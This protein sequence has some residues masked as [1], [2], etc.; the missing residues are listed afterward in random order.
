M[1]SAN[2]LPEGA[3]LS[4]KR[5]HTERWRELVWAAEGRAV[6]LG[7]S[8]AHQGKST[9]KQGCNTRAGWVGHHNT[10]RLATAALE[11]HPDGPERVRVVTNADRVV[12]GVLRLG[13]RGGTVRPRVID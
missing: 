4:A 11:L 13:M 1:Q 2:D 10:G 12:E 6:R 5:H 7:W 8:P 3:A 9:I